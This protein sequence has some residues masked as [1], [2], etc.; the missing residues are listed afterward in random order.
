LIDALVKIEAALSDERGDFEL[1]GLFRR[2]RA[3][4]W[5]V[6]VAAPWVGPQSRTTV[7]LLVEQI[8]QVAGPPA[9]LLVSR[10]IVAPDPRFI[11][12]VASAVSVHRGLEVVGPGDYGSVELAIGYVITSRRPTPVAV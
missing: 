2:R 7:E 1:F 12:A 3:T 4:D 5:D 6:V 9:L 8:R 11:D 10:I